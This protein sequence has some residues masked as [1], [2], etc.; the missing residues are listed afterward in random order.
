MAKEPLRIAIRQ[1]KTW[2]VDNWKS[3]DFNQE[4]GWQ[5]AINIFEDRI[6]GR[7]LDV[8]ESIQDKV[9][10]GFAIMALEIL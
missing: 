8:I 9:G 3:I 1:G 10:T 2:T 7:F 4:E 6:R 5:Q